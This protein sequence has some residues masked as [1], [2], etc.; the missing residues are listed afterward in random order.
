MLVNQAYQD[1][2]VN[3]ET[4]DLYNQLC[5]FRGVSNLPAHCYIRLQTILL[6]QKYH[7]ILIQKTRG[8]QNAH[9]K[10]SDLR[11]KLKKCRCPQSLLEELDTALNLIQTRIDKLQDSPSADF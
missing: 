6:F 1:V 10:L 4:R 7:L 5:G 11:K 3:S 2:L 8:L 9:E